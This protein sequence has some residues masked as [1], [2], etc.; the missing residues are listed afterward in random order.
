MRHTRGSCSQ[1]GREVF[2]PQQTEASTKTARSMDKRCQ[3]LT[4]AATK[5]REGAQGEGSIIQ[6]CT[7]KY[8]G[9]FANHS[10]TG[11]CLAGKGLPKAEGSAG[12]IGSGAMTAGEPQGTGRVHLASGMHGQ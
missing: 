9:N 8:S 12:S 10:W 3:L 2:R 6:R 11:R 4:K 7:T 5:E 1:W